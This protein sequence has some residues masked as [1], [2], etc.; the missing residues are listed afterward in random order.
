MLKIHSG[1]I[2]LR[3]SMARRLSAKSFD[4]TDLLKKELAM[5]KTES[6]SLR[7]PLRFLAQPLAV[8]SINIYKN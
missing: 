4:L 6:S 5:W 8:I 3:S 2:G 7:N 1:Y